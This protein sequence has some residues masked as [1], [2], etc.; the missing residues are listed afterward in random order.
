[1]YNYFVNL[2]LIHCLYHIQQYIS[3]MLV[4]AHIDVQSVEDGS[5]KVTH[6]SMNK[7]SCADLEGCL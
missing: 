5:T 3:V 6:P 2:F 4:T 1:M 7:Y